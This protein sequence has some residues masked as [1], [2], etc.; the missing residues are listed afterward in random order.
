VREEAGDSAG[1][2]LDLITRV[3]ARSAI[4]VVVARQVGGLAFAV[5]P[6]RTRATEEDVVARVALQHVIAAFAKDHIVTELAP[7]M[8]VA[9]PRINHIG[10]GIARHRVASGRREYTGRTDRPVEIVRDP[11]MVAEDIVI[12]RP[13]NKKV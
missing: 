13:C 10:C 11:I 6:I 4:Q 8:I 9:V 7:H 1:V 12:T 2:T 5:Q 3:V